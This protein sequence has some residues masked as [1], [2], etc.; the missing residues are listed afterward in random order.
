MKRSG[1]ILGLAIATAFLFV[2]VIAPRMLISGIRVP[3]MRTATEGG[4]HRYEDVQFSPPD[5]KIVLRGW[6]L[7]A[8]NPRGAIVIV[9]GGGANK[10][11]PWSKFSELGADLQARRF[12]VLLFDMRNHGDS[13]S[14]ADGIP[15]FGPR[16]ADDVIGAVDFIG[17]RAPGLPVGVIGFSMGGNVV[18][19]AASRDSRIRAVVTTETYAEAASVLPTAIAAGGGIPEWLVRPILWFAEHLHGVPI[20]QA[21]AIGVAGALQPGELLVIHNEADP[22]VPVGHAWFL[23]AA[24]PEADLWITAAPA[25][26]YAGD[27]APPWGTHTK[28]YVLYPAEYVDRVVAHFEKRFAAAPPPALA[29]KGAG[30]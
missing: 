15:S 1:T 3:Q 7:P 26:D 20:S 10:S 21:R 6:W 9:H 12:H 14:S 11:A 23:M 19:Y 30:G 28:S 29:Q 24:A 2:A 4:L 13:D 8:D 18:I 17:R 5:Q 25:P 27:V 16:E 22:I